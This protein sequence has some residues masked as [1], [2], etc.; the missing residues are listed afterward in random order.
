MT[1]RAENLTDG[2]LIQRLGQAEAMDSAIRHLYRANYETLSRY[3]INNGGSSDDA[4][5]VFQ[6]VILS[7]INLVA[8][9]RFRGEASI[10][11]FLFSLNRN[12]W[13]NEL[14]KRGRSQ[15]REINYEKDSIQV[16]K[17]A[18]KLIEHRQ[19]STALMDSLARLG[20]TCRQILVAFY[21]ENKSMK[22]ILST[23][24]YENEQVVRNKKYKCLKK[25][26]ELISS[27]PGLYHQ[28]KNLLQ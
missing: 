6:E 8:Q 28:M 4:Q 15:Q 18:A 21:F 14:K 23:L 16:E 11:T 5:D 2:E 17:T 1:L 24:H 22:E 9:N 3:V 26:E 7:F 12:I 10:K 19:A 13:L 20:D 27:D 25:L